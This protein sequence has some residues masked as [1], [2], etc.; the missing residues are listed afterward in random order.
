MGIADPS[1]RLEAMPPY[2]FAEL[3][4]RVAEKRAAGIDVIS[5]GIGDPDE[6]TYAHIVDAM[7]EAVAEPANQKY[8]SNRGRAEF[9]EAF[10]E[11]YGERFGVE[12]DPESEA[13][14]AIGA[15]ECIY[16]LC[17]AF[18]DPGG[19]ALDSDPCY[20]FYTGGPILA[21]ATPELL[22]LVPE[23]GF[24]PDLGAVPA[25]VA[26]RAR[27]MFLNYP[28]NPSGA[29]VPEGFFET[30]VSF[31]REHEILVV[32]DNAYSETT[33]DGY[34]APSFLATPGAK[35]VG[36]E[37]FSLSKGYNM[38]GWRCAAILGNAD[39]IQTYWRLKTNVDSGL[40]E[41]VQLAG[42][43]AL[44]GPSA[45]LEK[46]NETYARRRDLVVAA[47][48]EI[49]V[50]VSAP[51]GTIYVWAPV[52]EGHTSTSFAELV[53]E[54]AAVIVSPGSMYGPSGEGF[55]RI[56]LTT[57]DDRIEEAVERMR[58]HRGG[59]R[60][61]RPRLFD[62]HLFDHALD[63]VGRAALAV[64]DEAHERVAPGLQVDVDELAF[65]A[66]DHRGRRLGLLFFDRRRPFLFLDRRFDVLD[67]GVAL[68]RGDDQVVRLCAFVPEGDLVLARFEAF[69]FEGVLDRLDGR[70]RLQLLFG[71]LAA[72]LD[73]DHRVGVG[74]A[75]FDV[76]RVVGAGLEHL[77]DRLR[78]AA[79]FRAGHAA[80]GEEPV[81]ER[82]ARGGVL[83]AFDDLFGRVIALDADQL[84]LRFVLRF[85]GE[86]DLGFAR[87]GAFGAAELDRLA[88]AA[89]G[90]AQRLGVAAGVS[91]GGKRQR[92]GDRDHGS[93]QGAD[94]HSTGILHSLL[95]ALGTGRGERYPGLG[96]T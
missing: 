37:V 21:G 47:L 6:P 84:Q 38:T 56:S 61:S 77:C 70:V 8:P 83:E 73:R 15:K 39:A 86:G 64:A 59:A 24:A 46:M 43:A 75:G 92:G 22:P 34:V 72:D 48:R 11:F 13:I 20:P 88:C 33:Y 76:G 62:L 94:R 79:R 12:I 26:A 91:A 50:E 16:N 27:L 4:R 30:V 96:L 78:F 18:L 51:K 36:V 25:D 44:R 5:L 95:L 17:F 10:A 3:E 45:P 53:L 65:A 93:D 71:F 9:R 80:T 2:M 32:H 54:E 1:K 23:L 19:V 81:G 82:F 89:E 60:R 74:Q 42:A 66:F 49:G 52:P 67:R 68:D 28:N 35:E 57:P 90:K 55:F 63:G 31:A 29:I 40:F 7:R 87:V 41:A 58:E 85:V 69:V 14:P